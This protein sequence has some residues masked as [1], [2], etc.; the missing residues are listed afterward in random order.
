VI[1]LKRVLMVQIMVMMSH[2]ESQTVKRIPD[3]I[4][5]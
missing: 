2:K 4:R 3:R 1:S 5:C